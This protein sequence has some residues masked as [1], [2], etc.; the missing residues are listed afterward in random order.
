M[1]S[2]PFDFSDVFQELED[3][4]DAFMR[5]QDTQ[6]T[7][8][9]YCAESTEPLVYNLYEPSQYDAPGY[10]VSRRYDNGGLMDWHNYVV[11]NPVKMTLFVSNETKGN[12]Y[13]ARSQGWDPGYINDIIEEGIGYHWEGSAI[14]R[15]QPYPR[16][17]M[18]KA[19]EMFTDLFLMPR[20]HELFFND[21]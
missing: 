8:S 14:Y 18:E 3:G 16:P 13:W 5:E 9:Q 1:A 12:A 15:S 4:I 10:P 17:F 19:C 2:D 20:I 7:L 21:I 11:G 6:D